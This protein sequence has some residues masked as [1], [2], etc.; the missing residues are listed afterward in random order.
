LL[1]E[2][3]KS[4]SPLVIAQTRRETVLALR[5]RGWTLAEIADAVGVTTAAVGNWVS[6]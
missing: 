1:I 2:L 3:L 5:E 4:L 6:R